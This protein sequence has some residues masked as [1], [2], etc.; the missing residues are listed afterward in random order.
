M[1][2]ADSSGHDNLFAVPKNQVDAF[3]FNAA[4]ADVFPDMIRRSVPGYESIMAMLGVLAQSF[5]QPQSR[6]YDLGCSLGAATLSVA[7]RVRAEKVEYVCVDNSEAMLARCEQIMARHLAQGTAYDMRCAD[8][9]SVDIQQAS[10]ALLNFTL[11][12][13]A[14][15]DRDALLSRIYQGL[16]PG[17]ALLLSE[18]VVFDDPAE[19]Q[20]MTDLHLAFKRANGYSEMEI[21]QKRS[22]L[23]NVLIPETLAAHKVRLQAA[24]FDQVF[25]WFQNLN[26]ASLLAIKTGEA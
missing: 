21:S 11:Q 14:A 7:S 24:G 25:V 16:V 20:C 4:V 13:V 1:T 23:D 2:D 5:V 9:R 6:V 22:A 8:I 3:A 10:L 26:F 12:F 18:K 15:E 19:Q 17:G